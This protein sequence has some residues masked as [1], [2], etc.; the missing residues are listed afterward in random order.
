MKIKTHVRAGDSGT[1]DSSGNT[2]LS[3]Y[4]A[5]DG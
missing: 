5:S 4:T 2:T 3:G 1:T